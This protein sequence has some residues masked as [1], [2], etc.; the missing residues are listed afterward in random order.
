VVE[1]SHVL[2]LQASLNKCTGESS[3]VTI[4]DHVNR[5]ESTEC[6]LFV[7][8]NLGGDYPTP[9]WIECCSAEYR[10]SSI[11]VDYEVIERKLKI[12]RSASCLSQLQNFANLFRIPHKVENS[13]LE[14]SRSRFVP[15]RSRRIRSAVQIGKKKVILI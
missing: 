10:T 5:R 14:R 6:G 13:S 2:P 11:G 8:S 9:E 4:E 3:I 7:M 15:V 12:G 1:R